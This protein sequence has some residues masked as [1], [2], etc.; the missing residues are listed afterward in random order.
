MV[1]FLMNSSTAQSTGGS[2]NVDETSLP[3]D[4][5]PEVSLTTDGRGLVE[6]GTP[7]SDP[8]PAGACLNRPATGCGC[9]RKDGSKIVGECETCYFLGD[10]K[11]QQVVTPKILSGKERR[12]RD[13]K[14]KKNSVVRRTAVSRHDCKAR[15][16][17]LRGGFKSAVN[18]M[19]APR[20]GRLLYWRCCRR[21]GELVPS[22]QVMVY[23]FGEG[24]HKGFSVCTHC[25][26]VEWNC[27]T[28][29]DP[30]TEEVSR[31]KRSV[32]CQNCR[33]VTQT[34]PNGY[35]PVDAD[36]KKDCGCCCSKFEGRS[37]GTQTVEC[38]RERG[39]PL[40]FTNSNR[41]GGARK[42]VQGGGPSTGRRPFKNV[43]AEVAKAPK[44]THRH[45]CEKCNQMYEHEHIYS[46]PKHKQTAFHCPNRQCD[47]YFKK[48][49][50]P[51][52]N[53][54]YSR[55]VVDGVVPEPRL[56]E[57]D[58]TRPLDREPGRSENENPRM[59]EQLW[60]LD[61]SRVPV[62]SK[63]DVSL[64]IADHCK[65]HQNGRRVC[66]FG[67]GSYSYTG[68]SLVGI[69]KPEWLVLLE[70]AVK[71]RLEQLEVPFEE[72]GFQLALVNHYPRAVGIPFHS[73]N[74]LEIDQ[75]GPI[76][77]FSIG[78]TTRFSIRCRRTGKVASVYLQEGALAVMP[79]GFQADYM[80]AASGCAGER[81]SVTWR[82][83]LSDEQVFG[84][85][86]EDS[87]LSGGVEGDESGDTGG[88]QVLAED[89]VSG[90]TEVHIPTAQTDERVGGSERESERVAEQDHVV[91]VESF[92]RNAVCVLPG[93]RP[94]LAGGLFGQGEN[95]MEQLE[96]GL[97]ELQRMRGTPGE[98]HGDNADDGRVLG[99]P[100]T[101]AGKLRLFASG[102]QSGGLWIL[103]GIPK[104]LASV[105]DVGRLVRGG[106]L[107]EFGGG[108]E[109]VTVH[110][111]GDRV[112]EE[113]RGGQSVPGNRENQRAGIVSVEN[114]ALRGRRAVE[115][116]RAAEA[117]PN[118]S[119]GGNTNAPRDGREVARDVPASAQ[120]VRKEA[121]KK[122]G[123]QEDAKSTITKATELLG[124]ER[125]K[126]VLPRNWMDELR[127]YLKAESEYNA[128]T[129]VE[130][131][132]LQRKALDWLN[133]FDLE[134]MG[135]ATPEQMK[136][137][138][139][140]VVQD[141]LIDTS[142]AERANAKMFDR[143]EILQAVNGFLRKGNAFGCLVPMWVLIL[144]FLGSWFL[145]THYVYVLLRVMW[146][147]LDYVLF[148]SFR[149]FVIYTM[150]VL[151]DVTI[152]VGSLVGLWAVGKVW[153]CVATRVGRC[154]SVGWRAEWLARFVGARYRKTWS[155]RRYDRV[156]RC[157]CSLANKCYVAG[158]S[159]CPRELNCGGC[160]HCGYP[161]RG[162]LF[163]TV[164]DWIKPL[165]PVV[166]D[167]EAILNSQDGQVCEYGKVAIPCLR[168]G[169]PIV[170]QAQ[171]WDSEDGRGVSRIVALSDVR[172]C[173]W[174][175]E[176]EPS[177]DIVERSKVNKFERACDVNGDE[178][179]HVKIDG[180]KPIPYCSMYGEDRD[181]EKIGRP[182]FRVFGVECGKLL[183]SEISMPVFGIWAYVV[184]VA[185]LVVVWSNLD[186][187]S[188]TWFVNELYR[189][190]NLNPLLVYAQEVLSGQNL[191]SWLENE[192]WKEFAEWALGI[193]VVHVPS[194]VER[195]TA[196]QHVYVFVSTAFAALAQVLTLK[197]AL[198][199]VKPVGAS[200]C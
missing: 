48:G 37:W 74:E 102:L 151:V 16:C 73:D 116:T 49:K 124:P 160:Y 176:D 28:S 31:R 89:R 179:G 108:F 131:R 47:W 35:L 2:T 32:V 68:A 27:C 163:G 101:T 15:K 1:V 144:I 33:A 36:W 186:I 139:T 63:G 143:A 12:E 99:S 157:A 90:E 26:G 104:L 100:R 70:E 23:N 192:G 185:M 181:D 122:E 75:T 164:L 5:S 138:A 4:L 45:V 56:D 161:L 7:T 146:V 169:T 150:A 29:P 135:I 25:R 196:E 77:S 137:A 173:E 153:N 9:C 109:D 183:S 54:T 112:T 132:V 93:A 154:G 50:F 58:P 19:V 178:F 69:P 40:V 76:I 158:S 107:P 141:V 113:C 121:S 171:V 174:L 21:I 42:K 91:R 55:T 105:G 62:P 94:S 20:G 80:H 46:N 8:R 165:P 199:A 10:V 128:K 71:F 11:T 106:I 145:N 13:L 152:V 190:V 30:M 167:L 84:G 187:P 120:S 188:A 111:E 66:L 114:E 72:S 136:L 148:N 86:P 170:D 82:K 182:S 3:R 39:G 24:V 177:Y 61:V 172:R 155:M 52:K 168:D 180:G 194:W 133:K 123:E 156:M 38:K 22:A 57:V 119:T 98:V 88:A 95:R 147:Q 195:M 83:Y 166:S 65:K 110:T 140:E 162:G 126:K 51:H 130:L 142:A 60:V 67:E 129:H 197:K 59:V 191:W 149:K 103:R 198:M 79:P 200:N 96:L 159:D 125:D 184:G 189:T 81:F 97:G 92:D 117:P 53:V 127:A 193:R 43:V 64:S 18:L 34:G 87:H 41:N 14:M 44:K 175:D 17:M 118:T 134:A 115:I 6:A 78:A 85:T